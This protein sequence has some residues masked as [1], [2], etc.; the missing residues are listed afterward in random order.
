MLNK[1]NPFKTYKPQKNLDLFYCKKI[2]VKSKLIMIILYIA[3]K[4]KTTI[5]FKISKKV[6]I[7]KLKKK[8]YIN[9]IVSI[10]N[11]IL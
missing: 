1:K 7:Q 2:C 6:I 3:N 4:L 5:L 9:I 10:I 11:I 8:L